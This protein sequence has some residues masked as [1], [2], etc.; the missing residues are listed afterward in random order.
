MKKISMVVMSVV[1]LTT[2]ATSAFAFDWNRGP[3]RGLKDRGDWPGISKY[4]N[5]TDEQNT[6]INA[7]RKEHLKDIKPLQDEMFAKR[8][9]LRLMWLETEPNQE[10]ILALQKEIRTI[11]DKMQD[12][13]TEFRIAVGKILT[14]E[15]KEKLQTSFR[16]RGYRHHHDRYGAYGCPDGFYGRGYKP[17]PDRGM[18]GNR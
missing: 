7:L 1:F 5:L 15:Q 13:A 2:L 18:R 4:L 3:G 10:Q 11:R 16:N 17:G 6:S 12:K 14:P 9:D 8:G